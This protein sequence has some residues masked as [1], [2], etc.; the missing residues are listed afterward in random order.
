[1][2]EVLEGEEVLIAAGQD[3]DLDRLLLKASEKY[4]E[5][6]DKEK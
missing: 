3:D 1:M 2:T 4:G 6:P 5:K